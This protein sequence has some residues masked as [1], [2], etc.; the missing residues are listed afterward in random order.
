VRQYEHSQ[1]RYKKPLLFVWEVLV[2]MDRLYRF[3]S[4]TQRVNHGIITELVNNGAYVLFDTFAVADKIT[5]PVRYV[6][7]SF[8][9]NPYVST[10]TAKSE[11]L[12]MVADVPWQ[13]ERIAKVASVVLSGKFETWWQANRAEVTAKLYQQSK[14][15]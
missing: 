6:Y 11:V 2:I 10:R 12:P 5:L 15:K 3:T 14:N 9:P 7:V 4:S 1:S 8:E 13:D